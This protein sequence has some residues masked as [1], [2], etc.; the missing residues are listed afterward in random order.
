MVR[1]IELNNAAG[2]ECYIRKGG[3]L[4]SHSFHFS[5]AISL[6]SRSKFTEDANAASAYATTHPGHRLKDSSTLLKV[7]D[8]DQAREEGCAGVK[9]KVLIEI[10]GNPA[11]H[12]GLVSKC[13]DA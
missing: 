6:D 13:L 8:V 1:A 10:P 7:S 2:V 9:S 12:S 11:S 4:E 3:I 5:R